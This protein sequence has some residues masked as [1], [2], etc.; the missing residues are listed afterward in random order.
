MAGRE[1]AAAVTGLEA[2]AVA[3]LELAAAAASNDDLNDF[4][5]TDATFKLFILA[6]MTKISEW[7]NL[8]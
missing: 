7:V 8:A 2:A 1:P 3:G 5:T 6:W 4:K